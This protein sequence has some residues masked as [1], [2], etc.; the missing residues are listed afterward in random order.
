[1]QEWPLRFGVFLPPMHKTGTNPTLNLERDLELVEHLDRLGYDEVWVGEHHSAGSET[2]ASPE[3]FLAAAAQRTKHIR[4]GTGVNSLPYHHPFILADRLVLLDHLT[5][6]RLMC[7]FGPGQLTSDAM[8]LGLDTTKQRSM[9]EESLDVVMRLFAGE[10]VT[11]DAGWFRC[12]DAVLQHRPFSDP[13]FDIVVASSISPSGPKMAGKYGVGMLSLAATNPEGFAVL[14][15]HFEVAEEVAATHG[16]TVDR[17]Q[18]RLMGPMYV[19]PT[20]EQALEECRYGLKWVM[21]YIS[22]IVPS[23]HDEAMSYEDL[24]ASMNETGAAIIGTPEMAV[25]QIE[26]LIEHSGGFGAYLFLGAD[27]ARWP[28]Q[29][30]SYALFAEEVMPHFKFQ[31]EPLQRSYDAVMAGGTKFVDATVQAQDLS[32]A[33]YEKERAAFADSSAAGAG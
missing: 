20:V 14:D 27:F 23:A 25:A 19:A 2:V 3:V 7:G 12:V 18:W 30:R 4:L 22:H 9:M 24:V 17:K 21:D 11:Y 33:Q 29:K 26:R 28:E 15:S 10:T 1:M 13:L 16:T 8:M 31:T 6:G 32:K 5:R